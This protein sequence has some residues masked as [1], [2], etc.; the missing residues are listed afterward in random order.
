MRG[1]QGPLDL[2]RGREGSRRSTRGSSPAAGEAKTLHVVTFAEFIIKCL[3]K[4]RDRLHDEG[5]GGL[6]VRPDD[7]VP[8]DGSSVGILRMLV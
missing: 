8:S 5:G 2:K 6:M 4:K 1:S 3:W 7:V